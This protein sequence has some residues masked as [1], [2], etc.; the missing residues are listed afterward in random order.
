MK[1][2]LQAFLF[3]LASCAEPFGIPDLAS[4]FAATKLLFRRLAGTRGRIGVYRL[5]PRKLTNFL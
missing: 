2:V 5:L 1:T 3:A 4:V